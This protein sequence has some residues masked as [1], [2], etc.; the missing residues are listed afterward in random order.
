LGKFG[1]DKKVDE[2][3]ECRIINEEQIKKIVDALIAIIIDADE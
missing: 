3:T 1:G 2:F